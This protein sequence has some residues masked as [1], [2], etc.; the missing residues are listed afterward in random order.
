[1]ST[2]TFSVDFVTNSV[3]K[4]IMLI[5]H[6]FR[7]LERDLNMVE[8]KSIDVLGLDEFVVIDKEETDTEVVFQVE[9]KE[10][11]DCC[12]ICGSYNIVKYGNYKRLVKD[13]NYF[14]K[15]SSFVINGKRFRCRNCHMTFVGDYLSVEPNSK[16]TVR[17]QKKIQEEALKKTFTSIAE[18]YSIS[19][20]TVKNAFLQYV[21]EQE[22]K[23][24]L[25]APRV[26]GIDE[27]HLHNQ[28][29]AVLVD[30]ENHRI[31]EM[32]PKR[33]KEC[34]SEYFS[35][36]PNY[37]NVKVVTMDMWM[38]YRNAIEER[39][40]A[41]I[42]I[43]KFHIIKELNECLNEVRKRCISAQD[44]LPRAINK[45]TI[46]S[47]LCGNIE[48]LT[49]QRISYLQTLFE[50][51][52]ELEIAYSLKEAFRTIYQ[53]AERQSAEAQYEEWVVDV[54][55]SGIKE[56]DRFIKTVDTWYEEIFNYFDHRYTNG[57]TEG[58]NSVIKS[59][60]R[61][62]RGYSFDVL[63][64]KIL[65]ANKAYKPAKYEKKANP[66]NFS[67]IGKVLPGFLSSNEK[68]VCG[69]GTDLFELKKWLEE[70]DEI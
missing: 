3:D 21:E 46:K 63:R 26:L 30:V 36:L 34:I 7:L 8:N 43:D 42:V 70:S 39:F 16:I 40:W 50:I 24:I 48:D 6:Y 58:L 51:Y 22:R 31:I 57:V 59:I 20:Q 25:F 47:L 32:L 45:R 52:P 66:S 68:I 67:N 28:M 13:L 15:K 53:C 19:V 44:K 38:P 17:L 10:L 54:K 23:R 35:K 29:C 49:E 27:V 12:I 64:A 14:D 37:E 65:F 56:Y 55:S 11:P 62:G 69:S 1:M 60:E 41:K 61:L 9:P 18:D 5:Y 33:T 4:I 2:L